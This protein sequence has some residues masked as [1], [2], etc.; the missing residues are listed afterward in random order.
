MHR[1]G[2]TEREQTLWRMWVGACEFSVFAPRKRKTES[3]VARLGWPRQS[4]GGDALA[5]GHV[6]GGLVGFRPLLVL[7]KPFSHAEGHWR[8]EQRPQA[9]RLASRSSQFTLVG[10]WAQGR[11][12]AGTPLRNDVKG[13]LWFC[14]FT[15][16]HRVGG[17]PAGCRPQCLGCSPSFR[18]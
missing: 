15:C 6:C 2:K 17:R 13:F 4:S 10:K 1:K 7:L 12:G 9:S 11:A 16:L 3:S 8:D 14:R 18:P 5:T